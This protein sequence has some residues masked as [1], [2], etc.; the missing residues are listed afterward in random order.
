MNENY[1]ELVRA[2]FRGCKK[3]KGVYG[4]SDIVFEENAYGWKELSDRI[5][6]LDETS[7]MNSELHIHGF[8]VFSLH[9]QYGPNFVSDVLFELKKAEVTSRAQ[10]TFGA[11]KDTNPRRQLND[12]KRITQDNPNLLP[13]TFKLVIMLE[14]VFEESGLTNSLRSVIMWR[15][16]GAE[17]PLKRQMDHSDHKLHGFKIY[18]D[19]AV[20]LVIL[21]ALS[22]NCTIDVSPFTHCGNFKKY[23]HNR[24]RVPIKQGDFVVFRGDLVHAGSPYDEESWR[25]HCDI[26]SPSMKDR[27]IFQ[28]NPLFSL[29]TKFAEKYRMSVLE[30]IVERLMPTLPSASDITVPNLISPSGRPVRQNKQRA[31]ILTTN[32]Y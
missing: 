7:I 31:K 21:F 15:L 12:I 19:E 16:I 5:P 2:L 32:E 23:A 25:L 14:K 22:N 11:P 4:R 29:D 3:P 1:T 10:D 9:D 30:N 18:E 13:N 28:P 8:Q 24:V 26:H 6:V 20:P 27:N 17:Y